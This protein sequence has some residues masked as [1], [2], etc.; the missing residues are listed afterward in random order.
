MSFETTHDEDAD[1]R[2]RLLERF[3]GRPTVRFAEAAELLRM[4]E[5]TLRRHVADG[6]ITYRAT[7][8]GSVR[9]RREFTVSDLM[10]FYAGRSAQSQRAPLAP[11]R[12]L[13]RAAVGLKTFTGLTANEPK[14]RGAAR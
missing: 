10:Q 6:N 5:K 1:V 8:T 7:G 9:M 3:N 2:E 13:I 4:D 11:G 14:R 12:P